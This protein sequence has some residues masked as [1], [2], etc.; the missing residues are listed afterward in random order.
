MSH[1]L[2]ASPGLA[3]LVMAAAIAA[4]PQP[5]AEESAVLEEIIVTATKRSESVQDVPI[6]IGVVTGEQVDDFKINNLQDLQNFVPN[7]SV[8]E[9]F[10]NWSVRIRGLGSGVTNLA[11]D[12]SVSIF[13]DG[14]YCGRSRCLESAYLDVGRIEVARGP[15]GALFGKSTIAGALS[16]FAARPTDEFEGYM[17]A[18]YEAE[19]G[20]YTAA[21]MLSGPITDSLRGRFA[22]NWRDLD[23]WMNN[24]FGI[25]EEPLET[26]VGARASLEWDIT[27]TTMA[28]LKVETF[29]NEVDGRTAQL[30]SR[31]TFTNL[32]RDAFEIERDTTRR[33]ST[34]SGVSED[35]NDSDSL[36]VTLQIDSEVFG[37]TLTAI[38]NHW[39]L[40]YE[41]YLDVDGVPE[42]LVNS[43]LS[44]EY[45]QQSFEVR[46]LSPEEQMFEYIVGALYHRSDTATRQHSPFGIF[47][48]ARAPVPVG[49]DRNFAR[50][51]DTFSVYGQG[52]FNATDR[53]RVIL[54]V[55]YTE[56]EQK[57]AAHSF[58][59]S[60]PDRYTPVYT[61]T[62]FNQPPE[63]RFRQKRTDNSFD[64]SL[65]VQFDVTDDITLYAAYA[66]GSKPGGLKANDGGL[67]TQLLAKAAVPGFFQTYT[68]RATVTRT[69]LFN[70]ITLKEGNGVFDFE[71]EEAENYEIG[72]KMSLLDGRATLNVAVFKMDF[73]NLQT[74]SYN[75]TVFIIQNAAS[76]KS[77]GFEIEGNWQVIPELRINAALAY[78]NAK[79][80][81][82]PGAECI[83]ATVTGQF[84]TPGCIDGFENLKG[85]RLERSPKWEG[86][87]SVDWQ[88]QI[89]SGLVLMTQVAFYYSGDYNTRQDFHPL[90]EQDDFTKWDARIGLG[91]VDDTWEVA[92]V[93]RNLSDERV[94]QHAY[95]VA[96]T[97]FVSESRGRS[98]FI[99]GT[100][101]F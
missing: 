88:R 19:D 39:E 84:R 20:G 29:D 48:I 46:L 91:N 79:Y 59:V 77:E 11:F 80:K 56:E 18:G 41:L 34:G 42:L 55:R 95:E 50:D 86:N 87:L 85:E 66:E 78:S 54:D 52:T 30:V 16:V 101:R 36:G 17:Q 82:F 47:P 2:R 60:Y 23:G 97:N 40:D 76:A 7:L 57:G 15:Q 53:L 68:G 25:D 83:V 32:T 13:N 70:G 5:R 51:T 33:V 1:T 45:D 99:E 71:D 98:M 92:F 100:V 26:A 49:A 96:A 6:S 10:G 22:V 9:T 37:H 94:I 89:T 44:E 35:F 27:D 61:P 43:T 28:Y 14:I 67:G 72:A 93:G 90:G 75:G 81:D 65:R 58:P 3:G 12:S 4:A 38:A 63:Y 31:G 74:S 69:D 21:A 62:A 73:E 64:P 24:P 8:Q